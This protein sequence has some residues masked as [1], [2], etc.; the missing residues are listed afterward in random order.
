VIACP[1][2]GSDLYIDA[3]HLCRQRTSGAQNWEA[4]IKD[5]RDNELYRIVLMPDNKWWLA[6][7]LKYAATGNQPTTCTKDECGRRY[8]KTQA[9]GSTGSG[10]GKQGICPNGWIFPI[11]SEYTALRNSISANAV[12]VCQRLQAISVTCTGGNDYYGWASTKHYNEYLISNNCMWEEFMCNQDGKSTQFIINDRAG[13]TYQD[14]GYICDDCG[15]ISTANL[16][17]FRQL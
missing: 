2:T 7:N 6:Q 17:C 15:D 5:A 9:R 3:T 1:Y 14:C 12:V 16:R 11:L 13:Y 4:W 10:S 8:T